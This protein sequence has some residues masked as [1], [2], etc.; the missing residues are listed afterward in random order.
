MIMKIALVLPIL[1]LL[2]YKKNVSEDIGFTS[3]EVSDNGLQDKSVTLEHS[4][5][6]AH[7]SIF[8][9]SR[10]VNFLERIDF[11]PLYI[12]K[13]HDIVKINP[14]GDYHTIYH[15]YWYYGPETADIKVVVDTKKTLNHAYQWKFNSSIGDYELVTDPPSHSWY[16]VYIYNQDID[17][18]E[19]G[20]DF[21]LDLFMEVLNRDGE[22]KSIHHPKPPGCGVGKYQIVLPPKEYAITAVPKYK[23]N[24][25]TRARLKLY[26]H[27]EIYSNE[28]EVEINENQF[29]PQKGNEF[30]LKMIE[31]IYYDRY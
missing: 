4:R 12:G 9:D 5:H 16:P 26:G 20:Y 25:E 7:S 8:K 17:T 13:E 31:W 22:W 18:V 27:K 21:T 2:S 19:I 28:F 30:A 6:F 23:G 11:I 3:T 24:F 10:D 29:I 1:F 15:P 14:R